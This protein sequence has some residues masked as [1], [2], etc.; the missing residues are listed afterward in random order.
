MN[1]SGH[2]TY[3]MQ[4]LERMF[5]TEIRFL[6]STAGNVAELASSFHQDVVI[7]EPASLPYAGDWR[8]LAGIGAL[9]R[10]MS[11]VWSDVRVDQLEAAR[12]GDTIFMTCKLSL[13]S[14]A[15]GVTILQPFAEVLR[16]KDNLLIDGTPFY[17][18]AKEL[19]AATEG[20]L[21]PADRILSLRP[22]R[23]GA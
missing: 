4:L 18:D 5:E 22:K 12:V 1:S 14:R 17:F 10:A 13:T 3:A 20:P 9:F 2:E 11:S 6:K 15:T 7:H 23:A 8:G 21:S 19:V 16:L